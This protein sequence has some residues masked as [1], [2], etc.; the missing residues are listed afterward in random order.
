MGVKL[1]NETLANLP[2]Y[3][4]IAD[5]ILREEIAAHDKESII[6]LSAG[7]ICYAGKRTGYNVGRFIR[8]RYNQLLSPKYNKS[9]IY[10]RSTD[11][12]RAKMTVLTAMSAVYPATFD[13]WSENINWD[14]V[15]Y[16]TVPVQYDFN[17][18]S[19][20]CPNFMS[21]YYSA[22]FQNSQRMNQYADVIAEVSEATGSD[23]T[24]TPILTM[25]LY[26]ILVSGQHLGYDIG[27]DLTKLM[28]ALEMAANEAIDIIWG[29]DNYIA[30]Q[31][32]VL[33][34]EF[35]TYANQIIYGTDTQRV[36]VY[37]AHDFNVYS[38][39]A[40]SQVTPRQGA[41]KYGSVFSLELRRVVE[42]GE[43]VVL[44]VYLPSP[45]ETEIYLPVKGCGLPCG[46]D[47]FLEI[48]SKYLLDVDT[49]R[50]KC[51]FTE[52]YV[53]DSSSID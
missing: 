20:N 2:E 42:T 4:R 23:F 17:L 32:G 24:Q 6:G 10:I 49:W 12:T 29:D 28:P 27:P 35:F 38:L 22:I 53:I 45:Y 48:T 18:A 51:G 43:Y 16:T 19:L 14:P 26:D 9:E 36:R 5:D 41:P 40:V 46:L 30:L 37:S 34:N 8:R 15:P 3:Y 39:E 1:E 13:T 21:W 7:K 33:L 11:S 44:P 52:D 31:A 50:T 25:A 47:K